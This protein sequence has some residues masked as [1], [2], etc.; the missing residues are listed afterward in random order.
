MYEIRM[1]GRG[2]QG[3]V[4]GAEL[5]AKALVDEGK[6]SITVPAFGFERR[7]AP[8][9]AFLRFDDKVIRQHTNIYFPNCV[10][11]IDPT[12]PQTVDIF[13]G[14]TDN[15]TL[16]Q[17]TK[18]SLE[19]MQIDPK[20]K[21]V[22]LCNG[23]GIAL[24]VIGR[25]P[26]ITNTIMLGAFVKTTGLVSLESINNALGEMAFRDAALEKNIEAVQR[27]FDETTVYEL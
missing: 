11:C 14:I 5:L 4:M 3:A 12:L 15:A 20:V 26:A 25:K 24:E 8:V 21:K 9:V 13:D 2:G 10:V 23:V 16:V 6:Y 22:G 19:E 27:G 7:G 18:K 17:C 1:H